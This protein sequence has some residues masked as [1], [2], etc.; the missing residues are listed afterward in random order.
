MKLPG[1]THDFNR[2]TVEQSNPKSKITLQDALAKGHIPL[3]DFVRNLTNGN[4]Q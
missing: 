1:K 4:N 2:G 3:E